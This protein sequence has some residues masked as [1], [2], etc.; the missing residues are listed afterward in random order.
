MDMTLI[1]NKGKHWHLL[2]YP[3]LMNT[4][5]QMAVSRVPTSVKDI[6]GESFIRAK[7]YLPYPLTQTQECK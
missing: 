6:M 4:T 7:L 5:Q 2:L 1:S 3:H